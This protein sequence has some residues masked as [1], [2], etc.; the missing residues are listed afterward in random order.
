MLEKFGIGIDLA[1]NGEEAIHALE[2]FPYDLVFM[3]CQMPGM[4]GY[5]AT[6][7]M[8]SLEKQ[9]REG[10]EPRGRAPIIA[11]TAS[12]LA[13][14]R[15]RCIE[16]G[17]DE[18]LGKPFTMEQLQDVLC[19]WLPEGVAPVGEQEEVAGLVKAASSDCDDG[20]S[21]LT[22]D[23]AE[24]AQADPL[25]QRSLEEIRNL[26]ANGVTGLFDNILNIYLESSPELVAALETAVEKQDA[27]GLHAAAHSLK[28]TS[29]SLGA[30]YLASLCRELEVKGRAE[31]VETAAPVLAELMV[32]FERVTRALGKE[33]RREAV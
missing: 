28:S 14:D 26:E 25:D 31:D 5:E 27:V 7:R 24:E 32:E 29:A 21:N 10:G 18:Y 23:S 4:D 16:A 20:S 12:A 3:D 9:A 30:R 1:T 15:E 6:R 13:G 17:M 22:G 19:R 8:R 11:M 33:L 2:Q